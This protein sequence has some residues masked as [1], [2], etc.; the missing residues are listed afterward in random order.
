MIFLLLLLFDNYAEPKVLLK[1]DGSLLFLSMKLVEY[2]TVEINIF[3]S[4]LGEKKSNL[5]SKFTSLKPKRIVFIYSFII[6]VFH[7]RTFINAKQFS[8]NKSMDRKTL[9]T[10][11]L[12]CDLQ[13]R[14]GV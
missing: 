1:V 6:L 13:C 3:P 11:V 5:F 2:Q 4:L 9:L 10:S 14:S 7:L 12:L 8:A